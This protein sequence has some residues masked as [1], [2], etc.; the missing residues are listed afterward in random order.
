ML[1]SRRAWKSRRRIALLLV[2]LLLI[3]C[4]PQAT[5]QPAPPPVA[6][7]EPVTLHFAVSGE[8]ADVEAY[9]MVVRAF[10]AAH[11]DV[12][13]QMDQIPSAGDF[14]T[15]MAAAFAAG[16]PPDVMTVGYRYLG[17]Y[18]ARGVL[19]VLE[20]RMAASQ[21]VQ[22]SAFYPQALEAYR[23]DGQVVCVPINI[24]SSVI[25]YNKD[26]FDRAAIAY[27]QPDWTWADFVATARALTLDT[28]GDGQVDQWGFDT[29][30]DIRRL[31]PFV[32]QHGGEIVDDLEKPTRLTLDSPAA[33]EALQWF[34]DL[35]L[36]E[37]VRPGKEEAAAVDPDERFMEGKLA[38]DMGSRVA[39][40]Q[41][42][43]IQGFT[44]D[45][46]PLPRDQG[47]AAVLHSEAY[48]MAAASLV[49]D[50]AWS[51]I[52]FASGEP[53]QTIAAKA[54]RTV[55]SMISVAQSPAFL[56]PNQPPA[57]DQAWIEQITCMRRL[58]SFANWG[59]VEKIVNNEIEQAVYGD[60]TAADAAATAVEWSADEFLG[61]NE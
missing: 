15:K 22:P 54:G 16:D 1:S 9:A 51:F 10:E 59:N 61:A 44:W 50:A 25:Y 58:P 49:K 5:P 14:H 19:E 7:A 27:P 8:P 39:T 29:V 41:F 48:C 32:W 30:N 13:V 23:V 2:G 33:V 52:E 12:T 57:N 40:A 31:A 43:A 18:A 34:V 47:P 37:H 38:M 45:V 11:P 46:A 6:S 53:G 20:P 21:T 55:P 26:L 17:K 3:A 42:L 35:Q 56:S 24:S 36:K 60:V 4:N 28:D